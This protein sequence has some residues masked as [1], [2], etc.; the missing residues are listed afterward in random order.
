MA[1]ERIVVVMPGRGS[2]GATELSYLSRFHFDRSETVA[3]IDAVIA[4]NGGTPVSELDAL[5]KF[6][7]SKHLTGRN[8]SNL[9]YACAL[10]DFAVINRERFE[11]VAICGN[12]LGWYLTLAAS[13]ALSL[14]D[15]AHLVD[16][17]GGLMERKGVGGQF[18]YPLV[19]DDWRPDPEKIERVR[20]ILNSTPNA[21]YSIDL[22]GTAVLAGDDAAVRQMMA[23]LPKVDGRFPLRLPKH[24]AFHTPLLDDIAGKAR[25][26][27]QPAIMEQPSIPIIDGRG[28]IWTPFSTKRNEIYDYTLNTQITT[29]Y[30]FAKSLEVAAK[31]FAPDRFVL[32]GPGAS[33]GPPIAQS[34]IQNNWYDMGSKQAF[35]Q[36]Q[37]SDPVLISMGREDQRGLAV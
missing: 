19:D 37:K 29:T 9:I 17:M 10:S 28:H 36:R 24:S 13:G 5:S 34:F 27:L 6:S 25:S 20:S 30:D 11:I 4:E 35:S 26:I 7:P 32:A 16:T 31:Q 2:Y 18:L 33:L 15:G 23:E 12:S 21:Y 3:R 8:A 1:K 22:C 14:E